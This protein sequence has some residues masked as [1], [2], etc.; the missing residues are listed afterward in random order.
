MGL[1]PHGVCVDTS[2]RVGER[3]ALEGGQQGRWTC[4]LTIWS[5]GYCL[6]SEL[7]PLFAEA[8]MTARD[9]LFPA[10]VTSVEKLPLPP[11]PA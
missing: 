2:K 11:H 6:Y 7:V 9:C 5:P 1:N 4:G 8:S 3:V 10:K